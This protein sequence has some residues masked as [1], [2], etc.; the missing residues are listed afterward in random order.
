MTTIIT[1]GHTFLDM[2][3]FACIFAY[4]E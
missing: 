4:Q 1:S 2:D 3:S